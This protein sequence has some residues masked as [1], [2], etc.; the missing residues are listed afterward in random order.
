MKE[1]NPKDLIEQ[2]NRR[3]HARYSEVVKL[4]ELVK[5]V[6]SELNDGKSI[7]QPHDALSRRG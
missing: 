4:R 7:D 1:R 2:P 5:K 3:L 6:E